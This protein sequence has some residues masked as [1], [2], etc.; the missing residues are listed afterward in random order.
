MSDNDVRVPSFST[1]REPRNRNEIMRYII[2]IYYMYYPLWK[3]ARTV[4]WD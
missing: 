2:N 4:N 1:H 3:V